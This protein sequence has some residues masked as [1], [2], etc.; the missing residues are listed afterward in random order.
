MIKTIL[1]PIDTGEKQ[2]GAAALGLAASIAKAQGAK[3]VLLNVVEKVPGYLVSQLPSEFHEKALEDA[4]A[5][6]GELADRHG[7]STAEVVVR[8]GLP[9]SEILECAGEIKADMIVVASHDPGLVD[10]LLGSVAARVV[11]HAHCSVLVARNL[12]D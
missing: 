4:E 2:A 12:E 10:Y 3:L 5:A 8:A 1:V 6:L 7:L 11:R 9:S